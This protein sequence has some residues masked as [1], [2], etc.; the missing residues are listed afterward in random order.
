MDDRWTPA[1]CAARRNIV[2]R[3]Y[4]G[5]ASANHLFPSGFKYGSGL[6]GSQNKVALR[7]FEQL[8]DLRQSLF[9]PSPMTE[10]SGH[11]HSAGE[12]TTVESS[13]EVGSRLMQDQHPLSRCAAG[14]LQSRSD[15]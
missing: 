10:I 12:Q 15:G 13:H 11:R 7:I 5:L 6:R 8:Y 9:Q 14:G 2:R 1:I 4:L 3:N